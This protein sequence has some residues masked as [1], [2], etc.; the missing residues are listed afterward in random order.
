MHAA[1][2]SRINHVGLHHQVL[3][4]ELGRVGVVGVNAAY[5]GC[6]Q[7]DLGGLFFFK[8]SLH[9][10]LVGQVQIGVGSCDEVG[11]TL[12]LERADDGAADHASVACDVDFVFLAHGVV[13]ILSPRAMGQPGLLSQS[14]Q[15]YG[16]RA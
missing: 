5:F 8:E 13:S 10:G 3:V 6:G 16:C 9:C 7:V 11:L 1:P 12:L 14:V 15:R 2:E 4:D